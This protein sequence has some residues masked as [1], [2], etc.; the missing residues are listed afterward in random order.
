MSGT[1]YPLNLAEM[2]WRLELRKPELIEGLHKEHLTQ[3]D[4]IRALQEE[5]AFY[6]TIHDQC[7]LIGELHAKNT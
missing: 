7:G 6:R 1:E 4:T 2:C 5:L 3:K